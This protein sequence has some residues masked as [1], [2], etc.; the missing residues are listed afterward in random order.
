MVTAADVTRHLAVAL[1]VSGFAVLEPVT[2]AEGAGGKW[3]VSATRITVGEP[4]LIRGETGPRSEES[5]GPP[6]SLRIND[7]RPEGDRYLVY[8]C[9]NRAEGESCAVSFDLFYNPYSKSFVFAK[10]GRYRIEVMQPRAVAPLYR[11]AIGRGVTSLVVSIGGHGWAR[12]AHRLL[13]AVDEA[14]TKRSSKWRVRY[15]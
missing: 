12:Y 8:A 2:L 11:V 7:K 1:C 13:A 9:E 15:E 3:E 10:P 4:V 14:G 6:V 5:S